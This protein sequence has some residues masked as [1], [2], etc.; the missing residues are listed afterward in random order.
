MAASCGSLRWEQNFASRWAVAMKPT[1]PLLTWVTGLSWVVLLQGIAAPVRA[2]QLAD[3][4]V[5]FDRAPAL[6]EVGAMA[7]HHASGGLFYATINLPFDAGEALGGISIQPQI[8]LDG[9]HRGPSNPF[10]LD[11][12]KVFL[13]AAQTPG[14]PVHLQ[15]VSWDDTTHS[16]QIHFA[17]SVEPGATITVGLKPSQCPQRNTTYEFGVT[18]IPAAEKPQPDFLGYKT[19]SFRGDRLYRDY[20][21]WWNRDDIFPFWNDTDSRVLFWDV[22]PAFD[23]RLRQHTRRLCD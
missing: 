3:S 13:G 19:V 16:V 20:P 14:A 23:I 21:F 15:D 11:K 8:S 10:T 2:T 4:S 18:A 6:L 1:T 7:N 17:Q 5:Q 12:T 9:T 22:P